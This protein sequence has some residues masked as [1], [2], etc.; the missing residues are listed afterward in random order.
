MRHH[1]HLAVSKV[2]LQKSCRHCRP[3]PL[4]R[5]YEEALFAFAR[6]PREGVA[7]AWGQGFLRVQVCSWRASSG[8]YDASWTLGLTCELGEG[9]A[10]R[11]PS[12]P[13]KL[14][15]FR[16]LCDPR[17]KAA[18]SWAVGVGDG[19][20]SRGDGLKIGHRVSVRV[21]RTPAFWRSLQPAMAG[22]GTLHTPA[23][24][25]R[26]TE[27]VQTPTWRWEPHFPSGAVGESSS[28]I[29]RACPVRQQDHCGKGF[30]DPQGKRGAS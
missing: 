8:H 6:R 5:M 23:W 25:V 26:R 18:P 7:C 9:E 22:G 16:V 12:S 27:R 30:R 28:L 2:S 4:E 14:P 29:P 17:G 20:L 1:S 19:S 3:A 24:G 11:S 21:L 15:E 10:A 13:P